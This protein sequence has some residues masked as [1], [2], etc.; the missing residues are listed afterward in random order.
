MRALPWFILVLIVSLYLFLVLMFE[1]SGWIALTIHF[2]RTTVVMAVLILYFPV[3]KDIFKT[4]PPPYRDF[5]LAG[6]ILTELSNTSFSIW[7]EMGR[8]YG[9]DS[10]VFTSPVSGFFSLL[11]AIGGIAF[12]KAADTEDA[13]KWFYALAFAI[14]FSVFLVFVAPLFR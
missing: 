3:V 14:A 6:I 8:V 10:N 2:V 13:R 9:V 11:V 1:Y 5:L 4:V 12:L 7:N